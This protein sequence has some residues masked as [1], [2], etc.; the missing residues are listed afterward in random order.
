MSPNKLLCN[1]WTL[2]SNRKHS[3]TTSPSLPGKGLVWNS[4]LIAFLVSGWSAIL[5]SGRASS[6]QGIAPEPEPGCSV[7]LDS[8][9]ARR[10]A[11]RAA[12]L[13]DCDLANR[14]LCHAMRRGDLLVAVLCER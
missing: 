6:G 5:P 8:C 1:R 10:A 11:M 4:A 2:A 9:S 3:V 14:I 7:P 12:C 13:G